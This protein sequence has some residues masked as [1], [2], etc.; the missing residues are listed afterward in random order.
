MHK[1][2]QMKF[3]IILVMLALI[4]LT[5]LYILLFFSGNQQRDYNIKQVL[6]NGQSLIKIAAIEEQG[7]IN[8]IKEDLIIF[9]KLPFIKEFDTQRCNDQFAE[10]LKIS[11]AYANIGVLDRNGN[12]LCSGVQFVPGTINAADRTYFINA[13]TTD[14]FSVGEYQI[15]KVTNKATVNFGYPLYEPDGAFKGV[16]YIALDLNWMNNYLEQLDLPEGSIV[17]V[18]DHRGTVI[19]SIKDSAY[20]TGDKPAL[21]FLDMLLMDK[22][23]GQAE[24]ESYYFFYTPLTTLSTTPLHL[25][26]GLNKHTIVAEFDQILSSNLT[27]LVIAPILS[28]SL[29]LFL[30]QRFRPAF[31]AK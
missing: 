12:L 10:L 17:S 24:N 30:G 5:P 25:I 26:V 9:S 31:T 11:Q 8:Q 19:S 2:T 4:V 14:S 23:G 16:I 18:V 28:I 27:V 21:D 22:K 15:G 3:N 1:H 29:V 6:T 20:K 7:K 13:K